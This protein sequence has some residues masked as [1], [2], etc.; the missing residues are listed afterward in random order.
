M[1]NVE[2]LLKRYGKSCSKNIPDHYVCEIC[3]SQLKS[4]G[5][6]DGCVYCGH[7]VDKETNVVIAQAQNIRPRHN[8]VVIIRMSQSSGILMSGT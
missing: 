1:P 3:A 2:T 7:R 6:G 5:F 8:N 4:N